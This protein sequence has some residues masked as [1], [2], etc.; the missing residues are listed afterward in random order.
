MQCVQATS[1]RCKKG[2]RGGNTCCP[3][4]ARASHFDSLFF[5]SVGGE[6]R[7]RPVHSVRP[8]PKGGKESIRGFCSNPKSKWG[9]GRLDLD[10]LV[11]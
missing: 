11:F 5:S 6:T 10:S 9:R 7:D 8:M 2:S 1:T 4:R 3:R